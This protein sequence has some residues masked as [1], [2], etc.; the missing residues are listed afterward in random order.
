[1]YIVLWWFMGSTF[2]D[3]IEIGVYSNKKKKEYA[4]FLWKQGKY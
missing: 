1:M 4:H 2:G 3:D